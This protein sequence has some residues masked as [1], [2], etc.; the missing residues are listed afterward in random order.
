VFRIITKTDVPQMIPAQAAVHSAHLVPILV[1]ELPTLL[2]LEP[3]SVQ[4]LELAVGC[5]EAPITNSR[6][7]SVQRLVDLEALPITQLAIVSLEHRSLLL[8]GC[9]EA[10]TTP[11][12]PAQVCSVRPHRQLMHLGVLPQVLMLSELPTPTVDLEPLRISKSPEDLLSVLSL[13]QLVQLEL[14]VP[15]PT[16]GLAQPTL[17]LDY[18]ASS[19]SSPQQLALVLQLPTLDLAVL[20][21]SE[22]LTLRQLLLLVEQPPHL[23]LNNQSLLLELDSELPPVQRQLLLDCLAALHKP[24]HSS[25]LQDFLEASLRSEQPLQPPQL[26]S[27]E[28]PSPSKLPVSLETLSLLQLLVAVCLVATQLPLLPLLDC[29]EPPRRK[30]SLACSHRP[31]RLKLDCLAALRLSLLQVLCSVSN[32][33]PS[34]R[35]DFLAALVRASKSSSSSSSLPRLLRTRH[36]ATLF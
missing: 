23:E 19:N 27:L 10:P 26:D 33:N 29:L 36:T 32:S 3:D 28:A 22:P 12:Q 17:A 7:G 6:P 31:P 25:N 4:L 11:R 20:E 13:Q 1:L 8:A 16:A 35:L 5:L 30:P 14:L 34:S 21:L 2:Q 15:L 9:S 18:L 24:S